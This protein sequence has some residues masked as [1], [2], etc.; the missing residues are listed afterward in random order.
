MDAL[1]QDLRYA[2]R[3]LRKAPMLSSLAVLCLALGIGANA[4][5]FSVVHSTLVQPLP[6]AEPDC[7]V[8]AWTI[9]PTGGG[10]GGTSWLDLQDWRRE[11]RSFEALAGVGIQSLT[12]SGGDNPE[13]VAGAAVSAG[14]FKHARRADGARS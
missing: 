8:D 3:T 2:A 1:I 12:L 4:A 9:E 13:R 14:L 5:M 7:L 6:F 10:R 11:A